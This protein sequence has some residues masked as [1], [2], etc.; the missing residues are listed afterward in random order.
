MSVK[1]RLKKYI[2][3]QNLSI[4]DFEKSINVA[5]SYVNS[6]SKS[7]GIDK[8]NLIVEKYPNLNLDWLLTG[9]GEMIK[10]NDESENL[11]EKKISTIKKRILQFLDYKGLSKYEFYKITG[12]SNGVLS[13]KGGMSESNTMKFLSQFPDVNLNWLLTGKGEMIKTNDESEN[14]HEKKISTIKERIL[15]VAEYKGITKESFFDNM[16]MTYGS[17]KGKQKKSSL[18][19][20]AI[21]RFLFIH[22][23]IDANWLLT[24]KGQMIKNNKKSENLYEKKYQLEK[25]QKYYEFGR[26]TDFAKFL[27]IKPSVLSNWKSRNT[28]NIDLLYTKCEKIN[29]EW[30][31]SG[32]GQMLKTKNES[33]NLHE[34]KVPVYVMEAL[35]TAAL[36]SELPREEI[37]DYISVPGAEKYSGELLAFRVKGA[38][39][40]PTI[41]SGDIILAEK[42]ESANEIKPNYIY[43]V[44][45]KDGVQTAVA[46]KRIVPSRDG[47]HLRFTSDNRMFPSFILEKENIL[48]LWAVRLKL[49]GDFMNPQDFEQRLSELEFELQDVKKE[50]SQKKLKE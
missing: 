33:E 37:E 7:I 34:K 50:L 29:P 36:P 9:K 27:G 35:A 21:D 17:F 47:V 4:R 44:I 46:I 30:L 11:H 40:S 18:N 24:G 20:D 25:I 32:K 43:V 19:S 10:T 48:S 12:V 31:I 28:F 1:N 5:N 38:S 15:Y 2:A 45:A 3:N 49:T 39:M 41:K 14:L 16:G 8:I 23:D 26:D 42:L 6:I 13:Q 22:S